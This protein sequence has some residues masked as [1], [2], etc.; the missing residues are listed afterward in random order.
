MTWDGKIRATY[1]VSFDF[2]FSDF[3]PLHAD[4]PEQA[5]AIAGFEL[6]EY[7]GHS[8]FT[9]SQDIKTEILEE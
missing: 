4:S 6:T 3:G 8:L 1:S 2:E 7:L 9:I 5:K